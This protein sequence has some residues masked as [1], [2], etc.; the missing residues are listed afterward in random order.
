[1]TNTTHPSYP[2][3]TILEALCE[4]HF[5]AEPTKFAI[6]FALVWDRLRAEFPRMESRIDLLPPTNES[7]NSSEPR[8]TQP[9]YILHHAR[10]KILLPFTP[11]S[12]ASHTLAP[13]LGWQKM[14]ADFKTSWQKV[15]EILAVS[16]VTQIT[17]RY[18]NRVPLTLPWEEALGWL[19][20]GDYLPSA[21]VKTAPP[22]QSRVQTGSGTGNITTVSI[23][24]QTLP[25]GAEPAMIVDFERTISG[26]F[27]AEPT[28]VVHQANALH[29]DIWEMFKAI[30]GPRRNDILVGKS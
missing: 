14:E 21:V 9:R 2:N 28:V 13:Y 29:T 22:F 1:M 20:A 5:P 25:N 27:S 26:S 12:F 19:E 15:Q 6:D 24:H 11:G 17:V 10:R 23:G 8:P 7:A 4:I 30:K 16:H 3:P 18:I